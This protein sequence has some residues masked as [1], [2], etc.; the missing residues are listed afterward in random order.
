MKEMLG[1][2]SY[3]NEVIVTT[4]DGNHLEELFNLVLDFRDLG[5]EHTVIFMDNEESCNRAALFL[6]NLGC[7]WSDFLEKEHPKP[8]WTRTLHMWL[9]RWLL[10]NSIVRH[11]HNALI[12]DTDNSVRA[13]PY[14]F[15]KSPAFLG[16]HQ[17]VSYDDGIPEIN[18]GAQYGQGI[19]PDGPMAWI[20][21]EVVDR[22]LRCVGSL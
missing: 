8:Y 2:R 12:L 1:A 14:L 22:L 7:T 17:V 6:P 16:Y 18:C 19:S 3:R 15:L 5:M 20:T 4:A 21:A 11:G 9:M 13:D 10:F